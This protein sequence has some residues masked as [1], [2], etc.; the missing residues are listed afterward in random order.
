ML[1][2]RK[3]RR[4]HILTYTLHPVPALSSPCSR[5]SSF[6]RSVYDH[7]VST[8][9]LPLERSQ[10]LTH[11]LQ[12]QRI[13]SSVEDSDG[14]IPDPY[15]LIASNW[16]VGGKM[17]VLDLTNGEV[18]LLINDGT[19]VPA[20]PPSS[21]LPLPLPTLPHSPSPP[22][23]TPEHRGDGTNN[24]VRWGWPEWASMAF[25]CVDVCVC[26]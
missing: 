15:L 8:R 9:L 25:H 16:D 14:S 20:V 12:R 18:K 3:R 11:V 7:V 19:T 2:S 5:R 17:M 21:A 22:S 6:S 1:H 24:C 4:F 23:N 10:M 26:V 13:I